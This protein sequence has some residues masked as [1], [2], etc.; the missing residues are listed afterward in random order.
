M[1]NDYFIQR[2]F[3]AAIKTHHFSFS[4]TSLPHHPL[5]QHI[6]K[7]FKLLPFSLLTKKRT[8]QN[9]F[10]KNGRW[11][12]KQARF[13]YKLTKIRLQ[14]NTSGKVETETRFSERQ[15]FINIPF[16]KEKTI[17]SKFHTRKAIH[18]EFK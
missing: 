13:T 8:H 3:W 7:F 16:S 17:G 12:K 18:T 6:I 5:Q 4:Y 14:K 1:L 9:A 11:Q 10:Q 2:N 15:V